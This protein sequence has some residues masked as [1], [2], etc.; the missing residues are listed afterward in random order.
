MEWG[1]LGPEAPTDR[2]PTEDG[3]DTWR[4]GLHICI[5]VERR[6]PYSQE[7]SHEVKDRGGSQEGSGAETRNHSQL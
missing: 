2:V 1:S 6:R 3:G 7:Q 4:G 5:G